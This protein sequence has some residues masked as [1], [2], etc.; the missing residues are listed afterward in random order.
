[1]RVLFVGSA[2]SAHTPRW[3]SQLEGT[4]WDVHLFDPTDRLVHQ[5]LHDVTLHTGWKKPVP[6]GVRAHYRWPFSRGRYFLESRLPRVWRL[7]L[8]SGEARL[9]RLIRRLRPDCIHSLGLQHYSETVLRTKA[10][11]GG[12]LPAPWIYSCRGHDIYL[13]REDPDQEKVIRRVLESCDYYMCNCHRDVRLAEEYG[14]RGE[15]LGL[16]QGGGGYPLQEMRLLGRDDPPS[17]R[18]IL[19]V[20]SQQTQAGNVLAGIEALKQCADVLAG[21]EIRFFH[22]NS[23]RVQKAIADFARETGLAV[24]IVPRSEHRRIWSLLGESR[25]LLAVSRSDGIPNTMIEAMIMGAFPVQTNPGN[26]TAE[27]IEDGR[28]GLLIPYDDPDAIARA[29]HSALTDDAL[30]DQAATINHR[31]TREQIEWAAVRER[32]LGAYR[33][34]TRRARDLRLETEDSP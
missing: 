33:R 19:A 7:V 13:Y 5:E 22:L 17:K 2:Y 9:A 23:N 34:A 29:L 11:L 24:E 8:S 25:A 31:L 32:A 20:K 15:L 27:W 28:N 21:F 3:I 12:E 26:A 1:M 14:L 30:V 18:R 10:R 4:G 16:F 6:A